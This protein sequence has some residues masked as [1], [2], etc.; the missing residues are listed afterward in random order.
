MIITSLATVMLTTVV[1]AV[2]LS[3]SPPVP[4]VSNVAGSTELTA[5]DDPGVPGEPGVPSGD[6][7]AHSAL[8]PSI[9]C[10][11]ALSRRTLLP[12]TYSAACRHA[13]GACR[14][15]LG[16]QHRNGQVKLLCSSI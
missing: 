12:L 5:T 2:F 16:S 10:P 15:A 7:L 3:N 4:T 11:S 13:A 1:L 6:R 9:L 14:D 8:C